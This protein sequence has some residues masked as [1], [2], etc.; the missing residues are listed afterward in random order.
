MTR[1]NIDHHWNHCTQ[2]QPSRKSALGYIYTMPN[3]NDGSVWCPAFYE[4]ELFMHTWGNSGWCDWWFWLQNMLPHFLLLEL[5]CQ[6]YIYVLQF[7]VAQGFSNI[8]TVLSFI[9]LDILML[10]RMKI[11]NSYGHACYPVMLLHNYILSFFRFYLLDRSM[12]HKQSIMV[13]F[14]TLNYIY[15]TLLWHYPSVSQH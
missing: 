7:Y 9:T 8:M 1:D 3:Q 2:K 14:A 11:F 4:G 12:E 5:D 13:F 15:Y 6:E 10:A